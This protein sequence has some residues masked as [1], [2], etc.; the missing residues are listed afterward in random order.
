MAVTKTG[1]TYDGTGSESS[2]Q[3]SVTGISVPEDAEA[4]IVVVAEE[5]LAKS[6]EA[7]TADLSWDDGNNV[8]FNLVDWADGDTYPDSEVEAWYMLDTDTTNWPGSGD[9]KTLYIDFGSSPDYGTPYS[10]FFLKGL[11]TSDPIGTIAK[12]TSEDT[13]TNVSFTIT[14]SPGPSTGDLA[15]ICTYYWP[16][17]DGPTMNTDQVLITDTAGVNYNQLHVSYEDGE[18]S[19]GYTAADWPI[20][21]AFVVNQSTATDL[22]AN[23]TEIMTM[24]ES[25]TPSMPLPGVSISETMTIT[26]S[27][28]IALPLSA[29]IIDSITIVED[30]GESLP[31][32]T[33]IN[34]TIT[35]EELIQAIKDLADINVIEQMT[36]VE[37]IK[38][39]LESIGAV[40]TQVVDTMTIAEQIT[41]NLPLST[42]VTEQMTIT[43]TISV[44]LDLLV[45]VNETITATD[46]VFAALSGTAM[47]R[48]QGLLLG[49]Y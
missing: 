23:V 21:M 43:E 14:L 1:D 15:I 10:I 22:S 34:Q 35:L 5:G 9:N 36:I 13:N 48:R 6:A 17:P 33:Q 4:C 47:A 44:L 31:L 27:T 11:D 25:L 16:D 7:I 30:L 19:P 28:D 38:A 29:S 45:T 49:I 20:A 12:E 3:F 8:D 37:W 2:S 46:V 41:M 26:E 40:D 39:S 32:S 18:S 42:S 24:T